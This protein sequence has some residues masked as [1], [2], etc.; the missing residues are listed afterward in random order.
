MAAAETRRP[1]VTMMAATTHGCLSMRRLAWWHTGLPIN[2]RPGTAPTL[3]LQRLYRR[4]V[5]LHWLVN[6][7]KGYKYIIRF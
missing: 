3:D 1:T 2:G 4:L 7:K 5:P 6:H